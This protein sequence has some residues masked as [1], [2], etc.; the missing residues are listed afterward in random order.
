MPQRILAGAALR[1]SGSDLLS[2]SQILVFWLPLGLM[3]LMMAVEQPSLT[4]VIARMSDAELNLAAF[5]VVFALSLVV[6]SPVI[7]MLAAATA[8]ADTA[9]NYRLLLR[10]MHI[11][12]VSLVGLHLLIG[13]TPLYD[14]IVTGLLSVPPDVTETS[15]LPFVVMAPFSA[16]VGYRRLWQGVLIRHGKTW[17]VPITM[18]SR[19][20]VMAIVL[21][22]GYASSQMSGA[23]VGAVAFSSA[24]LVAALAAGVLNRILVRPQLQ[25][26][27]PEEVTYTWR[28]LIR[29]YA[30]LSLTT[31]IF[32]LSQPLVTFGIARSANPTASLAVFPVVNSYLFLFTSVG[33]SYQESA[34]ALLNRS[35]KS[36]PRLSRFTVILA[37]VMSALML[38]TAVTPAGRWWFRAVSGLGE[39]LLPLTTIPVLILSIVPAMMTFKAWYR[40]RYVSSGRTTVL[41]QG[42]VTYTVALFLC[43][44][45]GSGALPLVGVTVAAI[46]LTIAQGVENGYLVARS[47]GREASRVKPASVTITVSQARDTE[48]PTVR[49]LF[50]EYADWLGVDLSFQAFDEELRSLPGKYAPP[51]G[52]ILLARVHSRGAGTSESDADGKIA[53][54][55]ALRQFDGK[56]CEMK[57]LWVREEFRKLGIGHRLVRAVIDEARAAS[58]RVMVLDTLDSMAPALHLYESFGFQATDPYY[59]NP[60]PGAVYLRLEL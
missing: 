34:I 5:G 37:V 28:R 35:P 16:A 55:V 40:A 25:E 45:F 53:G 14:Y 38:L 46:A 56:W 60:L 32:L 27:G 52:R 13:L 23:M 6:E 1:R 59:N 18:I 19:L 58:Y 10:F 29:F 42:V 17:I 11:M 48:L 12:A 24:V 9:A 50:L 21:V 22:A 31:V 2:Y 7:Q 47:G 44:F 15:R 39:N 8:I 33:L 51:G 26:P 20:G 57:R 3:W 54:C 49:D 41:A 36:A 43:V 4:A 30:P